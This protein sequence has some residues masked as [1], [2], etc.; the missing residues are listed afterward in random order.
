[1]AAPFANI[2]GSR[3][4]MVFG[5][6]RL[7]PAAQGIQVVSSTDRQ[8]RKKMQ[9]GRCS[10]CA[11]ADR[12]SIEIKICE[13]VAL[14]AISRQ[15]GPSRFALARHAANHI[16]PARRRELAGTGVVADLVEEAARED[17]SLL[18]GYRLNRK[19]ATNRLLACAEIGDT[20]GLNL[21]LARLNETYAGIAKLTGQVGQLNVTLNQTN[22]INNFVGSPEFGEL[23]AVTV[24]ALRDFPEARERVVRAIRDMSDDV[25]P[26]AMPM[27]E[28]DTAEMVE[29]AGAE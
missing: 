1:V 25:A 12:V 19:I 18:D 28:G 7:G 24:N 3:A 9:P 13:G 29:L 27:I 5:H 26:P 16:S 22:T 10:I 8:S 14:S 20:S 17:R 11:H 23:V 6:K 4:A 15:W 21:M 2:E